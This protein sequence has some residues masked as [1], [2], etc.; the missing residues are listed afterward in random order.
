M[1][2]RTIYP[3]MY[4]ITPLAFA[5]DA[6]GERAAVYTW[7]ARLG[8]PHSSWTAPLGRNLGFRLVPSP[9]KLEVASRFSFATIHQIGA[10]ADWRRTSIT[11][12]R[13]GRFDRVRS[14]SHKPIRNDVREPT[15]ST[16]YIGEKRRV[17]N[18][19]LGG[20]PSDDRYC[21]HR[22]DHGNRA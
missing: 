12:V 10:G 5:R 19:M 13:N 14:L 1:Q 9:L 18:E 3:N 7:R 21:R 20:R 2:D 11:A 22:A 4:M 15:H 8:R 16:V 17:F 6:V